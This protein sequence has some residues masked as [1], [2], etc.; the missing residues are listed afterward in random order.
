MIYTKFKIDQ[1][2]NSAMTAKQKEDELLR[3]DT[4][5]E[6]RD[7][8]GYEGIYQASN[9][10]RIKSLTRLDARGHKLKEIILNPTISGRGYLTV[11][12]YNKSKRK[13]ITI[14]K[15]IAITF[16]NHDPCGMNI[17]VDHI[18]GDKLNSNLDNLQ[19]ITQRKNAS[20][21]R[22]G[23]TSKYIGVSW[24]SR[25]SKWVARIYINGKNKYLG[26]F[27][28][29]LEAAEAYQTELKKNRI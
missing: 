18:D 19:L 23:G 7:I 27:T 17:V 9:L 28:D 12:L 16:L 13:S 5:E 11:S 24:F 4:E 3:M 15:L 22:K 2:A 10:G 20:K 25:Y 29:E 8:E 21:D 1:V 14:H 26:T 6:F